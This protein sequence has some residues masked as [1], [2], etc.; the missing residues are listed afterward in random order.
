[1]IAGKVLALKAEI[2]D[3]L[4][5]IEEIGGVLPAI[6]SG[7]LKERLVLSNT[8]RLARIASGAQKVVGVNC[9]T[10]TAPSPLTTSGD[11]GFLTVSPEAESAQIERLLAHRAERDQAAVLA[12]LDQ[13]RRAAVEGRNVM[14]PSIACARAGAT[15]GEWA[16]V[17]R[18]VFGEYRAPTGVSGSVA[19]YDGLPAAAAIRQRIEALTERLGRRPKILVG[20]PGLDGHS[21]GAEQIAVCAR[22]CGFEVVYDGIR[23]T[24]DRIAATAL[25]EGVHVIGL[26]VLS[27][28]HRPLVSELLLKLRE[29]GLGDLPVVVGGIIP[30]EDARALEQEGIA[31][32]FTPKDFDLATIMSEIVDLIDRHESVALSA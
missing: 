4:D 5:R 17:L 25:E 7:Y 3:E 28:S 9:F 27:G 10:E 22:D 8:E 16:E 6:E 11:G 15:T 30:P 23:L 20:K 1:V 29:Q 24:P 14:E 26:S 12:S 13:L 31:R 18:Q 19:V 21:N 2:R 32:V